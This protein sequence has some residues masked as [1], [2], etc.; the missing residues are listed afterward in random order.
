L[1][2]QE[3]PRWLGS[4]SERWLAAYDYPGSQPRLLENPGY[5]IEGNMG[6]TRAAWKAVGGFLG[7]DQFGSP[8]MA[9]EEVICLLKQNERKGGKIAFVPN[10]VAHHHVGI[11]TRQWMLRRAYWHGVSDGLIDY[12]LFKRSW[13]SVIYHV[14]LDMAAMIA[15]FA[16]S[17]FFYLKMDESMAMYHL[18][19]TI[20]RFGLI[21]SEMR[22]VGDWPRARSWMATHQQISCGPDYLHNSG[23]R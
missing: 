6:L 19:R 10:A 21:L 23:E 11:R 5:V 3:R 1:G 15:L 9:S 14:I 2:Q 18:L 7:M 17:A 4:K 13:V 20:R 16:Y 12:F 22:L 8:H